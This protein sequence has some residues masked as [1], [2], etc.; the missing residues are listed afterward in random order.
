MWSEVT[1]RHTAR[2]VVLDKCPGG[3]RQQDLTA[4][5]GG[6]DPSG[7]MDVE[8]HVAVGSPRA[9]ASMDPVVFLEDVAPVVAEPLEELRRTLDVR[10][11][12]RDRAARKR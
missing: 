1:D 12:E 2:Q 10:E 6:A 5:G 8:P 4:V 3:T 9:D 7:P 11:E